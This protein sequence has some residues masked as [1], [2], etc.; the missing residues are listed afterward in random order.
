MEIQ[1]IFK[2][3]NPGIRTGTSQQD[4]I[5]VVQ[6]PQLQVAR[7]AHE[8][9]VTI[10]SGEVKQRSQD[11]N[12]GIRSK[13]RVRNIFGKGRFFSV[14]SG[15]NETPWEVRFQVVVQ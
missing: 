7:R 13:E 2:Q 4:E 1:A 6:I 5:A 10:G 14:D 11:H 12:I 15:R 3:K 9:V 8:G